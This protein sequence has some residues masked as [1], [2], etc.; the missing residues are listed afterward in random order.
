MGIGKGTGALRGE[1]PVPRAVAGRGAAESFPAKE[2]D[3][4][5]LVFAIAV[6][7]AATAVE[8]QT[9]LEIEL[10][11]GSDREARVRD[12]LLRLVRTYDVEPW[13]R[14][15]RIRIEEG[16]IP[17]SHPV[18]TLHTRHLGEDDALL[19]TFLHEEFHWME[20]AQKENREAA[21]AEFRKIYPRV[22]SGNSE[23][24]R[25]EYSTYLH[26]I[27][28]D[29]EYQAMT[30]L[31]GD[32]RARAVLGASGHYTWIYDRVLNDDRVRVITTR[33]GFVVE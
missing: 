16:V 30:K 3:V 4:R 28:C 2:A 26:L 7:T 13:I 17:H 33:H 12:Q 9:D 18:L 24:A 23:G 31:V 10:V 1:R 20:E 19:A 22:P 14:T 8:A 32:E 25:D 27:V 11:N 21:I 15:R 6:L 29:L 5:S